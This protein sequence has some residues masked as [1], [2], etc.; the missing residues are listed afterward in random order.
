M[1]QKFVRCGLP[2]LFVLRQELFTGREVVRSLQ[3]DDFL[4]AFSRFTARRS[5]PDKIIS[6]NATFHASTKKLNSVHTYSPTG[7]RKVLQPD[8]K[9][10]GG[11]SRTSHSTMGNRECHSTQAVQYCKVTNFRPVPIFVLLI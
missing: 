7:R 4:L 6:D 9:H 2:F 8:L 10:H 3:V 11:T 5:G 1:E